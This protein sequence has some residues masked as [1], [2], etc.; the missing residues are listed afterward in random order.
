MSRVIEGRKK[1]GGGGGGSEAPNTLRSRALIRI[2]DVVSEGPIVGLVTGDAKSI[3]LDDTPLQNVDDSFNY[4]NVSYEERYG[5]PSQAYMAGFPTVETEIGVGVN[6]TAATS[7]SRTINNANVN[8]VRVTIQLPEGLFQVE[9]DS[10]DVVGGEVT[11]AIDVKLTSSGTWIPATQQTI[12]GKTVSVYER[13]WTVQRP[14]GTTPWQVRVRRITADAPSSSVRNKTVWAR[15]TELIDLKEEYENTAYIGVQC[16]AESTGGK[17]PVRSYEIDGLIVQYPANYN[18]T[19]RAY[20]GSWNGTFTTGWTDNP[21]WVLYDLLTNER[22][23]MGEYITASDIDKYSFY[24]AAVYND[25]LVDDGFGGDEPRFTF[26]GV[27]QSR[28]EAIKLLQAVASTMRATLVYYGGLLRVNQDRPS[29]SVK[30][31]NNSHVVDGKFTYASSAL[32]QRTTACH[33]TFN[34]KNDRYMQ[35]KVSVDDSAGIARYGY[36]EADVTAYGCTSEG[37]AKR[38][39]KWTLYTNLNQLEVVK[40]RA[41]F[42]QQDLVIGDVVTITDSYWGSARTFRVMAITLDEPNI[43]SIEGIEYDA[44]KYDYADDTGE[45]EDPVFPDQPY[46]LIDPPT[47]FQWYPEEVVNDEGVLRTLRVEWT[48]S[49]VGFPTG[50]RV[51]WRKDSGNFESAADQ[52]ATSFTIPNP[53]VGVY[54]VQV[55]S[56]NQAGVQ[57]PPGTDTYTYSLDG[58]VGSSGLLPVQ[59]LTVKGGGTTFAIRDL[60][61]QW[62]NPS[63]NNNVAA[64]LKDFEV[65]LRNASNNALLLTEYVDPVGAGEYQYY[66]YPYARNTANGGP[67]RSLKVTVRARDT[68]NNTSA[69]TTATLS[70]PVPQAPGLTLV[71][72]QGGG[73]VQIAKN[74]GDVD[75]VGYKLWGSATNGFTPNDASN[76]LY[77]GPDNYVSFSTPSAASIFYVKAACYDDFGKTGLNVSAQASFSPRPAD[78]FNDY[79]FQGFTFKANDPN[80]NRV[81]W[82]SGT[83]IKSQGSG[84]GNSWTVAASNALWSSGVLYVYW[85]EAS[86]TVFQSTTSLTTATGASKMILGTYRGGLLWTEGGGNAFIDGSR[87]YA[88]TVA[89]QQLVTGTAV[90]TQSAQ[91]ANLIVSGSTHLQDATVTS[92]KIGANA[93][94]IPSSW[95]TDTQLNIG[96]SPNVLGQWITLSGGP[97]IPFGSITGLNAY[98]NITYNVAM[99]LDEGVSGYFYVRILRNGT[100]LDTQ[101][102]GVATMSVIAGGGEGG[103]YVLQSP[104]YAN[105]ASSYTDAVNVTANCAYSMQVK[106]DYGKGKLLSARMMTMGVKR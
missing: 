105:L 52:S 31:I 12:S 73:W 75:V 100:V 37:Q 33:V 43:V 21:A 20:T 4:E 79:T 46:N 93:I 60:N 65:E 17:L 19:T 13:A 11:V 78:N 55:V 76:L 32:I 97:S 28:D 24:D 14:S 64:T 66:E 58:S 81:S 61:I 48:A 27:I 95:G 80:T 83:V 59:Q 106:L 57:S 50:H 98:I 62:L 71:P 40:W 47:N 49:S 85:D 15:Y 84:A 25:E 42:N 2:Q 51:K 1:G 16:D 41:S 82:T 45:L 30:S 36:N 70:N 101:Q 7:A 67:L 89:A 96:T 3:Y 74:S 39:G 38:L 23:G 56:F 104:N 44:D 91:I 9:N 102:I 8:A 87:I 103:T 72:G 18:P 77:D 6:I 10:G 26:N 88:G 22:Y 63:G 68:L 92:I 53:S 69:A 94:T 29:S 5:L 35:R 90:I 99:R 34:D 86:P 54:E